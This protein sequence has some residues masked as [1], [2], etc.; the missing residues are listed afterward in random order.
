M[1]FSTFLLQFRARHNLTQAQLAEILDVGV[2]MIHRY[3]SGKNN[4]SKKNEI[5]YKN[6]IKERE[7]ANDVNV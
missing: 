7:G 2:G 4:P 5:K 1:D 3:E 6:K